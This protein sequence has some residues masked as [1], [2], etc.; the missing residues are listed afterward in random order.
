MRCAALAI[1]GR[2]APVGKILAIWAL[3][4]AVAWAG[5][6]DIL[7]SGLADNFDPTSGT[8]PL[9][10]NDAFQARFDALSYQL[11]IAIAPTTLTP[12]ETLG[13]NGF[14]IQAETAI[15]SVDTQGQDPQN[16][17]VLG[18]EEG[19]PSSSQTALALRVRK[20]LPYSFE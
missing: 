12:A 9:A 16:F 17:W 19:A 13:Y 7:L 18:T 3:A 15:T 20:G 14:A 4:P 8:R 5:P 6:N 10:Q 1:F 2:G 11:G